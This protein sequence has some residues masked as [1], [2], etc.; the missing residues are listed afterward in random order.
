MN[1]VRNPVDQINVGDNLILDLLMV[2]IHLKI[3]IPVGIA[4]IIVVVIK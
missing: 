1:I 2:K 4:I 3:L